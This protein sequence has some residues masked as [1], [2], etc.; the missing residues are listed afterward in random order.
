MLKATSILAIPMREGLEADRIPSIPSAAAVASGLRRS[1]CVLK[2]LSSIL[3]S[4]IVRKRNEQEKERLQEQLA[5]SQ[6]MEAVG[7]LSGGIAH[8]F[9]NMLLPI[10]GYT[11]MLLTTMAEDDPRVNDLA[12]IRRAA[13][14]AATLTRQLLA[15]SRK[16]VIAKS[17]FDLGA[18]IGEM[19]NMLRRIIGADVELITELDGGALPVK[20]RCRPDRAGADEPRDQCTPGDARRW[21]DPSACRKARS[22]LEE[23]KLVNA[24]PAEGEYAYIE[25]KD[26]GSGMD[27]ELISRIFEPFYTTKGLDGTGLGLSVVY[28]I[29]EQHDGGIEV[30]SEL[31]EGTTFRI[32]LPTS[33]TECLPGDAKR[34][35]RSSGAKK[36]RATGQADPTGRR[37]ARRAQ[38]YL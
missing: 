37:R 5:H 24:Q 29:I 7:K 21:G 9:N 38:F 26:E 32:I 19:E 30:V 20:R 1:R 28:G 17:V 13:D 8:D 34:E 2:T 31:G 18:A 11:D 23:I 6:K 36:L 35:S 16:Q 12:E 3:L 4:A 25:V 22:P 15:F 27:P 33:E 14:R 10:I